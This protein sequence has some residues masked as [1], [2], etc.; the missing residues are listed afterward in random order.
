MPV[1]HYAFSFLGRTSPGKFSTKSK[2]NV[3][4]EVE[5][6]PGRVKVERQ[7]RK[8][9]ENSKMREAGKEEAITIV[10]APDMQ[11][12]SGLGWGWSGGLGQGYAGRNFCYS[13]DNSTD[14]FAIFST[15]SILRHYQLW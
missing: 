4:F 7:G 6:Q 11:V 1:K 14:L 15:V 10:G 13:Q 9:G 3:L 12:I 5:E 8:K 2:V